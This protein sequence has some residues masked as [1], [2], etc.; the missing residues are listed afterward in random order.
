MSI[1]NILFNYIGFYFSLGSSFIVLLVGYYYLFVNINYLI[2]EKI[3]PYIRRFSFKAK[4]SETCDFHVKGKNVKA[5]LYKI[6][7]SFQTRGW[8]WN[9][10]GFWIVFYDKLED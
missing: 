3:L 9:S 2:C 6:G 4:I 10:I 1:D 7:P 8:L 5:A